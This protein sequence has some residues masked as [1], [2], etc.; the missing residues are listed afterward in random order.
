MTVFRSVLIQE[1]DNATVMSRPRI[2]TQPAKLIAIALLGRL[3][4]KT[5]ARH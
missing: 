4:R 2:L 3:G 5:L 1:R